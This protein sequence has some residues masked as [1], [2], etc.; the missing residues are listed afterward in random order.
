ML[1]GDN[2]ELKVIGLAAKKP[3]VRRVSVESVFKQVQAG[4]AEIC[5]EHGKHYAYHRHIS[6]LPI[7]LPS[8]STNI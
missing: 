7:R 1:S 3:G 6:F 2:K 8:V 5:V 4:V